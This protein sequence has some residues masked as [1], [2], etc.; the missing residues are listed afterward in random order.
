MP[1]LAIRTGTLHTNLGEPRSNVTI[2][3]EDD[4]IAS[5]GEGLTPPGGARVLE[6][7]TVIP[8]LI[9]GHAHLEMSGEPDVLLPII[10]TTPTQRAYVCTENARKALHAGVTSIRDVGASN[11]LSIDTRDA[12][13]AGKI[14]GP[15]VV[16]AG[17]AITMT[18]GHGWFISRQAD[19]EPDVVKAVREQRAAGATCIKFIATGGVLTKG[20]APGRA[21]FTEAELRAG[22]TEAHRHGMRCT[23]HAIGAEGIKNALRAGIDSIEHG[24]MV[25]EEGIALFLE[26][27]AYLV[28]TLCA[29]QCILEGGEGAGMPRF[30]IDKG[31]MVAEAMVKNLQAARKAGVKFAGGSDA[32]TPFNYHDGYAREVELMC[33]LLGM[34]PRESLATATMHAADNL[35]IDRGRLRENA[36]AD[37]VLLD[38][39]LDA[40]IHT[41][42]APRAVIKSGAV[43]FERG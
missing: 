8:G 36:I 19:G 32:G 11:K 38:G 13:D 10:A 27:G 14:P 2:V 25:D 42:K 21:E 37:L 7:R 17:Y 12:I 26:H 15:N 29:P 39:D 20:A 35:G 28:P 1:T 5:I 41:L 18:G 6:A 40:D 22:I 9:N 4:H 30:V 33:S 16:A 43:E 34:S 31:R 23:A 3:I 24:H